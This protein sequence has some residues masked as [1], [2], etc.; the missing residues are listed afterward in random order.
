MTC[1]VF[2]TPLWASLSERSNDSTEGNSSS[3][4]LAFSVSK[5]T[6]LRAKSAQLSEGTKIIFENPDGTFTMFKDGKKYIGDLFL[7]GDFE[8]VDE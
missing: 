8:L 3:S 7:G 1:A 5:E 6:D 2:S 4:T